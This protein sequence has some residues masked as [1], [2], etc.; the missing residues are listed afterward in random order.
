MHR[1]CQSDLGAGERIGCRRWWSPPRSGLRRAVRVILLGPV[2]D[3][4][5]SRKA[6]PGRWGDLFSAGVEIYESIA[7]KIWS[8]FSSSTTSF[9]SEDRPRDPPDQSL[10]IAGALAAER[11]PRSGQGTA[12]PL[13]AGPS[14][15]GAFGGSGSSFHGTLQAS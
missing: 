13:G 10:S 6:S 3:L 15:A 8:P 4:E 1:P 7:G 12:A 14:W 11:P 2:M 9:P 5:V